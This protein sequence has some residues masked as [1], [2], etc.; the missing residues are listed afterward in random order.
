VLTELLE[1]LALALE[2]AHLPYMIIGGQAVLLYG[3][4]RLTRDIDVTLGADLERLDDVVAMAQRLG[5]QPLVEPETFTRKTWVLPCGDPHTGLRV[6]F[7]FSVSPYEQQALERVRRVRVGEAEVR[8]AA[9]E[10]VIV[11]KVLSGRPRDLEDVRSMAL[12]NPDLDVA[13]VREWLRHFEVIAEKPL[14]RR[15]EE[16]WRDVQQGRK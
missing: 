2:A 6:D 10:D 9:L 1:R 12:K 4:P 5:L 15:F 11:H 7:I 16:I 8:F 3:E 14:V 13:Y